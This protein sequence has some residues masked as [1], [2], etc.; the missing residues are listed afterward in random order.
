MLS[1]SVIRIDT[2]QGAHPRVMTEPDAYDGVAR[3]QNRSVNVGGEI[4][5][6]KL[7]DPIMYEESFD[8]VGRSFE[9]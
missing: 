2:L 9:I 5:V 6:S 3:S 1:R 7:D 8:A 4:Q